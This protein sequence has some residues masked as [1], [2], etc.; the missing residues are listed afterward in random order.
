MGHKVPR[1][2]LDADGALVDVVLSL[3]LPLERAPAVPAVFR[4]GADI[5]ADLAAVVEPRA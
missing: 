3:E 1:G 4:A 5:R 2:L